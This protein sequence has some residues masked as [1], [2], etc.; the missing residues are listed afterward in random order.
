[1]LKI[2]EILDAGIIETNDSIESKTDVNSYELLCSVCG[3]P[4][5]VDRKTLEKFKKA[6]EEDFDSKFR[7]T[8]REQN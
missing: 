4:I 8:K 1:M 5:V 6:L 7:G 3:K 2:K